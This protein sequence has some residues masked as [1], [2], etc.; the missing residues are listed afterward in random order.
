M[1]TKVSKTIFVLL[2]V[3]LVACSASEDSNSNDKQEK[4]ESVPQTKQEYVEQAS[5]TTLEGDSV[6]ISDFRGKVVLIDFW[7]T[8]CQPCL[9]SFVTLQ[10]LQDEYP[11]RFAVLA[12]TPG[13]TDTKE[14]AQAFANEHD[15]TFNYLYDSN[16]LHRKLEIQGIPY[17]VFV[18]AQGNF[19]KESIG[20]HGPEEDY[21]RTK[22][23]IEEYSATSEK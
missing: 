3:M 13:F 21:K 6:S 18:D 7:E 4:K 9:A 22:K 17:K 15:Y 8:W 11:D 12:V 14:D 16:A 1:I 20:S 23:I 5:F 19:I 2:S 10:E